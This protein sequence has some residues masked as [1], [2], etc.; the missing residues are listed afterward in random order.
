MSALSLTHE[1]HVMKLYFFAAVAGF[2]L[3]VFV[4]FA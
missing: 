3:S 1:A 2:V 4:V